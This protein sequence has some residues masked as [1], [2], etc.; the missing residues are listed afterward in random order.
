MGVRKSDSLGEIVLDRKPKRVYLW[1]IKGERGA[2]RGAKANRDQGQ[3]EKEASEGSLKTEGKSVAPARGERLRARK[4]LTREETRLNPLTLKG[5]NKMSHEISIQN[6]KAEAAFAREAAWHGL[7]AVTPEGATVDELFDLAGLGWEVEKSGLYVLNGTEYSLV[8]DTVAVRRKDT[9]AALGVVTPKYGLVQNESLKSLVKAAVGEG[10]VA[11]SAFAIF[12]GRQVYILTQN[13]DYA[14]KAGKVDDLHKSYIL[15]GNSHDGSRRVFV[16]PTDVRVV[17]NNTVQAAVGVKGANIGREGVSIRHAEG[18]V[19]NRL[20]DLREA[21]E[22][23]RRYGI[24]VRETMETLAAADLSDTRRDR[25]FRAVVDLALPPL[26]AK[27]E[28]TLDDVLRASDTSKGDK[29][30]LRERR[31]EELLDSILSDYAWEVQ[32][33]GLPEGSAYT[34]YQAVSDVF[35][36]RGS[37]RGTATERAENEFAARLNG[38]ASRL[39]SGSLTL[40]NE[41]L[42][43]PVQET[44]TVALSA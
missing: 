4:S 5:L 6:G 25:F 33:N 20:A 38:K 35:E 34:A 43:D 30:S 37:Y 41:I 39:R 23:A 27:R 13:E 14:I 26:P 36:S 21:L 16:L 18:T 24:T 8:P 19:Q 28:I 1:F 3:E 42:A 40:L 12:G 11:E 15:F 44:V 22:A 29:G 32:S 2:R 7:G 10:P 9:G 17:C 31:R